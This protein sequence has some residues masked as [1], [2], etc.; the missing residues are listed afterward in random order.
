MKK[1]R[2]RIVVLLAVALL[3]VAAI[4]LGVLSTSSGAVTPPGAQLV[5]LGVAGGPPFQSGGPVGQAVLPSTPF[6]ANT[7][8]MLVVN[9]EQYLVDCGGGTPNNIV[10]A[11]FAYGPIHNVFFTHLHLDH[12][13]GYAELIGR[14]P[15]ANGISPLATI[16][17]YGPPGTKAMNQKAKMFYMQGAQLHVAEPINP[18]AK[19]ID[20]PESG[21]VQIYADANVTVKATR[22]IHDGIDAYAYR[23]DIISGEDAGKSVVFSGDRGPGPAGI[24][25]DDL[26]ALAKDATVLV[27]DTQNN[28]FIP[29]IVAGA[30]ADQQAA[31]EK[32]LREGHTDVALLPTYAKEWNVGTLVLSHYVPAGLPQGAWLGIANGARNGYTGTIIAPTELDKIDF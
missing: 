7:G 28:A 12:Y 30:P 26:P 22:V 20:L 14:G 18:K 1:T 8:F 3:V 32:A 27:H 24:T 19:S 17:A 15:W 21:I 4:T 13:L 11:G 5:V 2:T 10:R 29:Q 9:G 23:F 16:T 6:H 31:I 25:P